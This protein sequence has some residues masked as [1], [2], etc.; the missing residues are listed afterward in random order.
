MQFHFHFPFPFGC[1]FQVLKIEHVIIFLYRIY[2]QFSFS[3]A[4]AVFLD[5][6]SLV[7]SVSIYT[8]LSQQLFSSL[9]SHFRDHVGGLSVSLYAP[10]ASTSPK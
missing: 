5:A 8:P 6:H 2:T 10:S 3:L 9:S 1:S 4:S 7:Y